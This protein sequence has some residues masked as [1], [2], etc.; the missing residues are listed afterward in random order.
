MSVLSIIPI[1]PAHVLNWMF[2]SKVDPTSLEVV[3]TS[4]C[5]QYTVR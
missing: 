1:L 4:D 5:Y 2:F 3:P